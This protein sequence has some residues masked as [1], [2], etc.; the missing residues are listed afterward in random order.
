MNKVDNEIQKYYKYNEERFNTFARIIKRR[1][2]VDI[3]KDLHLR[4]TDMNFEEYTF[5]Y[6]AGIDTETEFEIDLGWRLI[7]KYFYILLFCDLQEQM[8]MQAQKVYHGGAHKNTHIEIDLL[9]Q[10][11]YRYIKE[12]KNDILDIQNTITELEKIMDSGKEMRK[13]LSGENI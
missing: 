12:C 3:E 5:D 2:D 7:R 11:A 9:I 13:E 10:K 6:L 1:T 8:A 4:P